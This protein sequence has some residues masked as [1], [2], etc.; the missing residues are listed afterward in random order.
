MTLQYAILTALSCAALVI[1]IVMIR[2]N[3]RM[4]RDTKKR[5]YLTYGTIIL[6]ALVEAAGLWLNGA[7]AW[8]RQIHL[9]AKGLDYCLTPLIGML[10]IHQIRRESAWNRLLLGI[11]LANVILQAASF[12]TG[13]VYYVDDGNIYHHGPLYIL[14][15]VM[16]GIVLAIAAWQFIL[17]S[18]RFKSRNRLSLQLI[19]LFVV[20]GIAAQEILGA[21]VIYFSL[22][23]GAILLF[24][25]N[26]E[27]VQ[28]SSDDTISEQR[29]LLE[30]DALTG[31]KSRFAY[32]E[33]LNALN[34]PENLPEGTAV[35]MIDING[36]K[37]VND[38]H[39]HTAGDELIRGVAQCVSRVLSPLR[40]VLPHRR[41]RVRRHP[42]RPHGGQDCRPVRPAD[43]HRR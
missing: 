29:T 9:A 34:N 4:A 26:N 22:M 41:R 27:Y 33:A 11:M 7:P 21:R 38:R 14:Y 39:G 15:T 43:P 25:H 18:R 32:N 13:W 2:E 23:L 35:F 5:L 24:I 16:Y 10:F 36:L 17:Y 12:F 37:Q 3:G 30:T 6:A 40:P 42:A 31:M 28:Q 8:T 1:M 20:A 19:V